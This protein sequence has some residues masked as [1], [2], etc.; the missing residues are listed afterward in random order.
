LNRAIVVPFVILTFAT[1][2]HSSPPPPLPW[3]TSNF[4]VQLASGSVEFQM[5]CPEGKI[6]RLSARRGQQVANLP[7]ERLAQLAFVGRCS[8]IFTNAILESEGSSN[9]SGVELTV[10]LSQEYFIEE[11]RINFDLQRFQFTDATWLLTFP[12][13]QTQVK[14]VHLQ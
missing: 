10:K 6:T 12:E 4:S 5:A 13:E 11:L 8:G 7:V 2:A 3:V 9:V 14:R 1:V